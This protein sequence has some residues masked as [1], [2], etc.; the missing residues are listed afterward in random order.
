MPIPIVL[1]ICAG[2]TLVV[3]MYRSTIAREN[4]TLAQD[5]KELTAKLSAA[6][7]A[8]RI[9]KAIIDDLH[10]S[11]ALPDGKEKPMNRNQHILKGNE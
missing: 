6:E 10:K 1:L 4:R 8:N 2:I 7:S 11:Y 9:L 3:L 5:N